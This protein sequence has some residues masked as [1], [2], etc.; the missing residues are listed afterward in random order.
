[1][2]EFR[3]LG[4]LHL[5]DAE[6]REVK[7]L[8]T[9]SRRVALLAYLAAATPRGFHRRD[10]L[11]ALFWPELDQEHA[12][13]ALRQALHVVRG[14]L[15]AEVVL[16]RGDEEIRL[17][18][19][20]LSCDVVAFDRAV[21]SGRFGEALDCYQGHLLDG[22]FIPDAGE[23][24]RW[25]EGERA[26]LQ[27]TASR[28]AQAL[29]AQSEAAG[30]LHAALEW[31]RRAAQLAPHEEG[32]LRQLVMLLDRLG[33]RAGAVAAYETFAKQLGADL[34]AEPAAE[35]KA[36]L[37]AVRARETA[38]P[39][40]LAAPAPGAPVHGA[41]AAAPTRGRR[42]LWPAV[43]VAALVG[44]VFSG[45]DSP[46]RLWPSSKAGRIQSLAVLPLE[47][48]SGDSLQGWFA[49]GMTEALITDL[50]RITALRVTSGGAV[51]GFK[52]TARLL[53]DIARDLRVDA[54][55]EGGVQRS[56]DTVR[57]DLRLIDATSGY[58]VWAGRIEE[59]VQNR[60][61]I[62]DSV[63][64]SVVAAL[65][66]P[67]TEAE[68]R[69]L[70]SAPTDNPAAYELYL[71]GKIRMRHETRQDDS[72]A[73]GLLERAVALDPRFAAAH[74]WLARAYGLRVSQLAREDT[75]ALDKA[76]VEAERAL[77][78][79]PDLAEA[80]WARAFLLWGVTREFRHEQA[81]QEDRRAIALNPNLGEAHHHL[82]M[83]YLHIGLLDEA[84]AEFRTALTL[85]PF[86][87]NA[88]R[89]IGIAQIY[90]G[91]YEDGLTLIRQAGP[92]ANP[93]LWTYQVAWALLYLG[94][95]SEAS[96]LMEDYLRKYPEDRGGLV[97][98]TR[99]LLRAKTGDSA[100]ATE[101]IRRAVAAGKEFIHFHHSAYN[102]ASA[103]A[104]LH[105]P[106]PA[107][108]WLRRAA[109]QGWPCYPYF[110]NDPNLAN[111]RDDPNVITF[112]RELKARWERYRATW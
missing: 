47:N 15:G 53:R 72:I 4:T 23:F 30:D 62:E 65:K 56:G 28:S 51:M 33:D 83:I 58:Q 3:L 90:R 88:Q 41:P 76:Y 91:K 40:E 45:G 61:A 63:A 70:R 66:L 97:R 74:A 48:L 19:E 57:V 31:A 77:Q 110:A 99:A 44:L 36:L 95:D 39:V 84:V 68:A 18:F 1:M 93:A 26:R 6:G 108:Q 20:R 7:S 24:E 27:Q 79:N 94:R 35:T 21:A 5:T 14:S 37:A 43:I 32:P 64:R 8:L 86:D 29:V 71:R 2:I 16:T 81:I 85:N 92:E 102:I 49:D 67:L 78:L 42:I 107:V 96:A 101:D 98:S 75:S 55:V 38:A 13:A 104:M 17:D 22:F 46:R 87:V 80:Y 52:G 50:G 105:R 25:L 11:L 69:A 111:I 103:Y 73:I 106:D 89:R 54:V 10:T 60:F 12:R 34:E 109:D 59:L 9:R 112:M 82:G 100:A